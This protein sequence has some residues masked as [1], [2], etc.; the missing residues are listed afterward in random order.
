MVTPALGAHPH[1]ADR[2]PRRAATTWCAAPT[3]RPEVNRAFDIGGPDVLT[4]RP[5]DAAATRPSAGLRSGS[6]SPRAGA[7]RRGSSQ[8]VGRPRHARAAVARQAAGRVACTTRRS[9]REHDIADYIPDPPGGLIGFDAAVELALRR[10]QR[11]RRRDAL[12]GSEPCRARRATR[13]PPTRTGRAAPSTPTSGARRGRR[14]AGAVAGHRGHRRR[15]RLVLVP[16]G[17]GACAAGWTGSS[18]GVGLRRGR[19]DPRPAPGRR[20][21]R[22]LAGRGASSA[23]GCCGCGP[24][25]GCPGLAWLELLDPTE[26]TGRRP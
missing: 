10:I 16:A 9:C 25:C 15:E 6:S 22:L 11:G 20:R 2:G 1:P 17:L 23:A 3:C 14:P 26:G 12:V 19:R 18:G 4:Y 13:C 21:A 8:P 7:A 5:D 24:R